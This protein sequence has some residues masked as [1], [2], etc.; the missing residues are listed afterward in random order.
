MKPLALIRN[1]VVGS[2]LRPAFINLARTLYDD[3]LIYVASLRSVE[4]QAIAVAV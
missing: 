3:C 4:V 1:D 2:L